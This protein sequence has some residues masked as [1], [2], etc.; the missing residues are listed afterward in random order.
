MAAWSRTWESPWRT[1]LW[2]HRRQPR[3]SSGVSLAEGPIREVIPQV[4]VTH[5]LVVAI[6]DAT[7]R[8]VLGELVWQ[9][10]ASWSRLFI[11]AAVIAPD[12]KIG[13]GTVVMAGAIINMGT[14]IQRFAIINSGAIVDHDNLI[15]DNVQIAAGSNLAGRVTC[16]RDCFIGT[17]VRQLFR[18]LSSAR[19]HIL[20]Q[21]LPSLR[22][23]NSI[24]LSP[25]VRHV[26]KVDLNDLCITLR[27]STRRL[28]R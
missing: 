25:A 14:M 24:H 7:A 3:L 18:A 16:R 22:Q 17:G 19:V 6:G 21:E 12:V 26:K 2:R 1:R 20:R 15:E 27:R 10:A 5:R 28:R 23:S 9:H 11:R 4:V 8:R 13:Q